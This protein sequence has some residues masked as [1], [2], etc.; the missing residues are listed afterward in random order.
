[1][2]VSSKFPC[3]EMVG[4]VVCM[5]HLSQESESSMTK[6][7]KRHIVLI[8][9][10]SAGSEAVKMASHNHLQQWA[11]TTGGALVWLSTPLSTSDTSHPRPVKLKSSPRLSYS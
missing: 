6:P 3:Y 2:P 10:V 4:L 5:M 9:V 7:T 8:K 11:T 1:M